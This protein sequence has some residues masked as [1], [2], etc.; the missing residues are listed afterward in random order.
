MLG[1]LT[2]KNAFFLPKLP[3]DLGQDLL[4]KSAKFN[5]SPCLCPV[6]PSPCVKHVT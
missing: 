2:L 3:T 6:D 5:P 1:K 4:K